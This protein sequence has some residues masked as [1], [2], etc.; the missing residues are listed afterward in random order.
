ML[1]ARRGQR[2]G[3]RV[4]ALT[5]QLPPPQQGGL[6]TEAQNLKAAV[7]AAGLAPLFVVTALGA[8][9][10]GARLALTC[11]DRPEQCSS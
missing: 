6:L 5:Q 1:G 8:A 7:A 2:R 9:I 10:R 4:L 11:S 3:Q